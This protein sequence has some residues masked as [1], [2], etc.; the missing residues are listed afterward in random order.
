MCQLYSKYI[1]PYDIVAGKGC[2][3]I[4]QHFVNVA[5]KYGTFDERNADL[6]GF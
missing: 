3:D 5:A 4:V 1:R 2:L 6:D